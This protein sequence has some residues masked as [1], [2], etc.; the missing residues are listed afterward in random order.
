MTTSCIISGSE[1]IFEMFEVKMSKK[2]NHQM[3]MILFVFDV[4]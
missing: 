4:A 2:L 3:I 1:N